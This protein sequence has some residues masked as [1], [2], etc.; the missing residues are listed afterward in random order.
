MI[1]LSRRLFLNQVGIS[2]AS[3]AALAATGCATTGT[4][5][6]SSSGGKK[7]LTGPFLNLLEKPEDNMIA[8]ARLQGNLDSSKVKYGW[9][10][11]MVSA[12]MPDKAVQDLFM[13][14]G[15]SCTRLLPK[16][17]GIGFVYQIFFS[18]SGLPEL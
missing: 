16:E 3:A 4:A 18:K 13:L 8:Y 15:F 14:E 7:S 6:G 10:K 1:D 9:Y 17:D 5:S 2:A 11:G 12:V